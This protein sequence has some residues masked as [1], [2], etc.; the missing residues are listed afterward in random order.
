MCEAIRQ[1][2]E[3]GRIEGKIESIFELLSDLGE[4]PEEVKE[5]ISNEKDTEV[6]RRWNRLAAKAE[7]IEG[8]VQAM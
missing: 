1:L 5:K 3:Q 8:F 2:K 7:T 4:V 6:L